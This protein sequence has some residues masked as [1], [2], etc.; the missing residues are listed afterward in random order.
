MR[1]CG[2]TVKAT[3]KMIESKQEDVEKWKQVV[4]EE[5]EEKEKEEKEEEEKE[6]DVEKH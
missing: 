3:K 1:I 2:I 4:E 5:E 6:E